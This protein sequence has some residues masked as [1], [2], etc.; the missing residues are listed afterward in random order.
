MYLS[1]PHTR[2]EAVM[3]RQTML[4]GRPSSMTS[5]LLWSPSLLRALTCT[6]PARQAS[7]G[8]R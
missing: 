3:A 6:L 5:W 1:E 2:Q 4:L 7:L 8:Q